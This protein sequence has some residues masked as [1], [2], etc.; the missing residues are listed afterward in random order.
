MRKK[1]TTIIIITV[2]SILV[3]ITLA[4]VF[5]CGSLVFGLFIPVKEISYDIDDWQL[6]QETHSYLPAISE[7]GNYE[8][9]KCKHQSRENLV[10]SSDAYI[11]SATYSKSEFDIQKEHIEGTYLFQVKVEDEIGESIVSKDASFFVDGFDFKMLSLEE[12]D[13]YYPKYFVL[14]GFSEE[15]N[16]VCFV[17]FEDMELDYIRGSFEDFLKDEC[18]W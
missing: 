2:S 15:D 1:S 3:L 13:L 7:M 16:M 11:L 9:L 17:F 4:F 8:T 10:I 14:V 18:G 5:L 12:Y 6:L